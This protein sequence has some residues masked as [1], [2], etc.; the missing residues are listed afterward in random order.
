MSMKAPSHDQAPASHTAELA[1]RLAGLCPRLA[2]ALSECITRQ[3]R[4]VSGLDYSLI[5]YQGVASAAA[6]L[7][8]EWRLE[9]QRM[10]AGLTELW[11]RNISLIANHASGATHVEPTPRGDKRFQDKAWSEDPTLRLVRDAYLINSSW[12][13]AQVHAARTLDHHEG[14]KLEFLSTISSTAKASCRFPSMMPMPSRSV[15]TWQSRLGRWC[16]AM[17]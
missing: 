1:A 9:P 17:R 5:D 12:L 7:N 13:L 14:Q 6:R 4:A 16:S 15:E 11:W 3:A 2:L 8:L 10:L